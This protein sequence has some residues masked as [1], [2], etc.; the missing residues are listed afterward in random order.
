M[1]YLFTVHFLIFVSNVSYSQKENDKV[2]ERENGLDIEITFKPESYSTKLVQ[3]RTII[4]FY[5][6]VDEGL[7]GSPMLPSKT[8]FIAI[9]PL[10]KVKVQL[11]DQ[12]YNLINNAEIALNPEVKFSTDSILIYQESKPDL[13]KYVADQFPLNE[14]EIIDYTWLRDYY[15]AVIKVSTH[16][17]NWKKKEIRELLST[18]IKIDFD[19]I[20]SYNTSQKVSGEFDKSLDKIIFNFEHASQFRADRIDSNPADSLGSW[21][22]YSREYVNLHIPNDGI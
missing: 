12:K 21:I 10:S 3:N 6:S 2:Y 13:S 9:P 7:P 8:Y 20:S 14:I 18:K 19:E 1:K 5:N 22:D 15:C 17:Y 11:A 4:E 16:T